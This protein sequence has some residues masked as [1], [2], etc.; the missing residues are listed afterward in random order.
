L[1]IAATNRPTQLLALADS[2]TALTRLETTPQDRFSYLMSQAQ[3][4][5]VIGRPEAA[6][7]AWLAGQALSPPGI[8]AENRLRAVAELIGMPELVAE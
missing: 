4:Q 5:A 1:L 3:M 6:R 7:S 2:L 8:D